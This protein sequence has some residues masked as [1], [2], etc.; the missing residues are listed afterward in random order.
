MYKRIQHVLTTLLLSLIAITANANQTYCAKS[1]KGSKAGQSATTCD[2][3]YTTTGTYSCTGSFPQ[4]GIFTIRN[5]T[6]VT[7][8]LDY[9]R[10]QNNGTATSAV[11]IS[12]NTCGA[13]LAPGASCSVTV[14]VASSGTYNQ[15]LLVGVNSRQVV[16]TSPVITLTTGCSTSSGV[17]PRFTGAPLFCS[18]LSL[19]NVG[20]MAGTPSI[21]NTGNTVINGDLDLYPASAT[22]GFTFS[23]PAGPGVVNGAVNLGN[24]AALQAQ[25]D[26]TALNNCLLIPAC[27][28][29]DIGLDQAGKT[30]TN[31]GTNDVTVLCSGAI[32]NSGVLTLSGD[33]NSVF[34]FR[35]AAA[36]T[37]GNGSS[38]VLTGG[39]KAANVFW[40]VG[41]G[42]TL[43]TTAA[44]KGT[45]IAN[46][47]IT[48]ANNAT[49]L[50]R[51]LA[52]TANV[53]FDTN[54]VTLP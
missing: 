22:T 34:I 42:A 16:L 25:T 43:G 8:A 35:S 31:T 52:Q 29:A 12:A 51:A 36:L 32:S 33:A 48:L 13:T 11:T 10:L 14:S 7:M 37:I 53:T 4:T 50:G 28:I 45:I 49:I 38:I 5:N 24:A 15:V 23:T 19:A 41:S 54:T 17:S 46:T 39:V 47:A 1:F 20:V 6:P 21:T 3:S 18:L 40:T 30:F 26:S 9:I 27:T 2:L 44:F